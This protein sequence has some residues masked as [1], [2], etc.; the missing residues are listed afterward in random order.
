MEISISDHLPVLHVIK[1]ISLHAKQQEPST[2][3]KINEFTLSTF[4]D[5]ISRTSWCQVIS[6]SDPNSAFDAFYSRILQCFH[7]C[8]PECISS[9]KES[10]GNKPWVDAFLKAGITK[11]KPKK[12]IILQIQMQ[13]Y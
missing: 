12:Q 1:D 6:C 8:F 13:S 7:Q 4:A 2:Y 3:H 5:S 9:I 10:K 11:K